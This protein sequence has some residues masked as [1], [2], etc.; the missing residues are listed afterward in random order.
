MPDPAPAA[1]PAPAAPAPIVLP[2]FKAAPVAQP[3]PEPSAAPKTA[4]ALTA[5]PKA[6]RAAARTA[7]RAAPA[8][9]AAPVAARSA[10]PVAATPLTDPAPV[11]ASEAPLPVTSA[12]PAVQSA[13]ITS[14][15][16]TAEIGLG[17]LGLV[18][19]G[20]LGIYTANRRRRTV[21]ESDSKVA[22]APIEPA[23]VRETAPGWTSAVVAAAPVM[24]DRKP[25][26]AS[27]WAAGSAAK[28]APGPLPTGQ[29]LVDLFNRM[30]LAAPDADNP[31]KGIKRRRARVRW[32]MKQH[33][34]RLREKSREHFDFRA[35]AASNKLPAE[36]AVKEVVPA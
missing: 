27:A 26:P 28:I 14:G 30:A 20:G 36:G 32:L 29:A 8:Q 4:A 15:D 17:V 13:A 5:A 2:E 34:Y 16:N 31:F 35:Y 33:E 22:A 3:A 24:F 23:V 25:E 21:S 9:A 7:A 6:E 19:L 12:E 18:A 10:A 1:V 11:I